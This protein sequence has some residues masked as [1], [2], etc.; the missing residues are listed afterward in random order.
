MTPTSRLWQADMEDE[1]WA[2]R[3]EWFPDG[4]ICVVSPQAAPIAPSIGDSGPDSG[5]GSGDIPIAHAQPSARQLPDPDHPPLVNADRA[6]GGS[7][8][9]V[10][11]EVEVQP[12]L[13]VDTDGN[14][15]HPL[16]TTI[17]RN[18]IE[19]VMASLQPKGAGRWTLKGLD[20]V[21]KLFRD[22]VVKP[23]SNPSRYGKSTSGI[24]LYG[25][26]GTGKTSIAMAMA[27]ETGSNCFV[28]QQRAS[29]DSQQQYLASEGRYCVRCRTCTR[30]PLDNLLLRV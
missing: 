25:P 8:S 29:P 19:K 7:S 23:A 14:Y 3:K 4:S 22:N 28:Y 2:T 30:R 24:L 16:L 10:A 26:P 5:S 17:S 13:E 12:R 20:H 15:T 21:R 1:K 6:I 27:A 9:Q 18:D 11:N